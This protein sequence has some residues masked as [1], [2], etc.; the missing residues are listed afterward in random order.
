MDLLASSLERS[1]ELFPFDLNPATDQITLIRFTEADYQRASFLDGRILTPQTLRR[2]VHWPQLEA[3]ADGL[4]ETAC[5]IF[6]IGHVGST[7]LSRLLG[8]H[9][10]IFALREPAI[11][12]TLTQMW[13]EAEIRPWS[14][15]KFDRRLGSILKL[16]SRT[17][18]PDQRAI[19]K[20]TSFVSQLA[21]QILA[22]PSEA[23]AIF[24]FVPAE[25]YLATILGAP[26]SPK[27]ARMLAEGRLR[28]LRARIAGEHWRLA[29][30]GEGEVVAMSWACEMTT[31]RA[32]AEEAA[33]RALWVNFNAFL[34]SPAASLFSALRHFGIDAV[35]VEIEAILSGPDL[36]C[37]AKAPEHA[38]DSNLRS[39]ILNRARKD[40]SAEIARGLAWLDRAARDS[41]AIAFALALR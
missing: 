28:R 25:T 18:R 5:Y 30:L 19:V 31:I 27:E 26:N 15:P 21:A 1:P 8:A 35:Q 24:M 20:T 10:R 38:F 36:R 39:E 6:H 16:L 37:Y 17:F 2:S 9:P 22:R 3:A 23:K 4:E 40:H 29:A 32:A 13:S 12:R 34:E 11:L 7:L 41:P 33:G 14:E